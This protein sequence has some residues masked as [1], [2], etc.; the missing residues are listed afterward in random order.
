MKLKDLFFFSGLLI[1]VN[2]ISIIV[3]LPTVVVM[4]HLYFEKYRCCCCGASRTVNI[5]ETAVDNGEHAV[6]D[7]FV[8][9]FFAGPYYRCVCVLLLLLLLEQCFFPV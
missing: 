8:V 5:S 9:K 3:Y 4:Y 7:N 1:A 2:Y 6:R